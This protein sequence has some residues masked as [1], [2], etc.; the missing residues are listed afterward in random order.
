MNIHRRLILLLAVALST[1]TLRSWA[2]EEG[3]RGRALPRYL[4]VYFGTYTQ[5]GSRGIYRYQ[6]DTET[7]ALQALGV[8]EGVVNPS[9]L[10]LHPSGKYLYAVSEIGQLDGKRTGG[11]TAFARDEKTGELT[12]LNQQPSN[13]EGPCH[14]VVDYSGRNVLVANYGGGNVSVLPLGAEG[15]LDP[16]SD[17]EQHEGS[18]VTDRQQGPHAH[19]VQVDATN[20]F[21]LAADLGLDQLLIYEFDP[22][23]GELLPNKEQAYAKLA[24]GAG[25]RHFAFHPSG[26]YVYVINEL[27]STVTAFQFDAQ[28]GKLDEL[29]VISSLPDDFEGTNYPAEIQVHPSGKFVYGSNR[30]HDSLAIFTVLDDGTLRPVGHQ[31]TGGKNP[32]NFGIDPTGRYLLAANQDSGN[33]LVFAIDPQ[34]GELS[35][36]EH[37]I[38]IPMPVCVKFWPISRAGR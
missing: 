9:F 38:E 13:G 21:A 12:M 3:P 1:A 24:A 20:R 16:P 7:G 23:H 31:K 28:L 5:N 10:A 14:L 6:F 22:E 26:R 35:E 25:P 27:N 36:T 8:T 18:S 15:R 4:T 29:Q 17:T 11:V 19:E 2:A 34:T 37:R 30:G 32:R 33:V